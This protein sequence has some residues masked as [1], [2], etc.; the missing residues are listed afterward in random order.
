MRAV[1]VG[2]ADRVFRRRILSWRSF[3][4]NLV[5]QSVTRKFTYHRGQ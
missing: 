3:E 1:R 5:L 4:A 2:D